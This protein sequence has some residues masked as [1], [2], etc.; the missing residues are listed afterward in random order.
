[1]MKKICKTVCLGL[2]LSMLALPMLGCEKEPG[3]YAWYGGK[4]DVEN[5]MTVH[6]DV[7]G[8]EKTYDVS[9]D[10]YRTVYIY[11][12]NNVTDVILDEEGKAKALATDEEKNIAV[13]E[14]TEDIL[15]EYYALLAACEKY[16]ISITEADK[17]AYYDSYQKKLQ[18]YVDKIEEND[19]DYDGTREEYAKELYEKS[20]AIVGMT[21]EYFEFSHY[22]SLLQTRLKKAVAA[23]LGDYLAQSYYHYKQVLI[24]YTKGDA[25][26]EAKARTA[27]TEAQQKLLAGESMDSVIALYADADSQSDIY[28]DAYG[29]I[30]ASSTSNSLG[31]ITVDTVTSLAVGEFS[32]IVSGDNDDY[33][34]YFAILMREGF[35]EDYICSTDVVARNIYEY[36]Y[37]GSEY[38]TPHF[39]R[40]TTL[41]E[42]YKQNTA[43]IPVD[44]KV[45]G[46]IALNTL[47]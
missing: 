3:L 30:V 13:K 36:A 18:D 17:Q 32:D 33:T 39:S 22:R 47:Y 4:M 38:M 15:L 27:I 9:L 42:G 14:V 37:V 12:K 19:L 40:Y 29:N 41:I 35:D 7:G 45:Y 2:A 43:L 23:D 25:A 21:P 10:T 31:T 11:L 44:D 46:R 24:S 16:G 34:G 28:F 20:L 1:M 6:V 5:V 8:G 26:A